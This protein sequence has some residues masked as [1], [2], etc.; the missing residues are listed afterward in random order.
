[1]VTTLQ[2]HYASHPPRVRHR[3]TAGVVC[4][5]ARTET[6][7]RTHIDVKLV[8]KYRNWRQEHVP[9]GWA[10]RARAHLDRKAAARGPTPAGV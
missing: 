3:S 2:R 8:P 1:M 5:Y 10:L 4:V 9:G 7:F 6:V